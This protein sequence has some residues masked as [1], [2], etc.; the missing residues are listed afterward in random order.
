MDSKQV[1]QFRQQLCEEHNKIRTN[2][3]SYV[4]VL[5]QYLKYFQGNVFKKPGEKIGIQT[6]E[7]KAAVQEC[8][9]FLKKQKAEDAL[10]LDDELSKAAQ[11]HVDDI[12]P[13]GITGHDGSD[14]STVDDRI[15]RYVDWGA[16]IAENI[17]FGS[18]T[19]QDVIISLAVDDGVPSRGH[20]E[21]LFNPDFRYVGVGFGEHTEFRHATVLDYCG[22][23]EGYK[24]TAK[25]GNKAGNTNS[26]SKATGGA[27]NK[28]N[29]LANLVRNFDERKAKHED[30]LKDDED[31]PENTVGVSIKT[32]TKSVNGKIVKKTIKTYTLD[33]G[34]VET[35]E[36]TTEQ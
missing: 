21:N 23:I 28:N 32:I 26:A 13:Q 12:G 4:P 29:V 10:I 8:I 34:S 14:G 1:V 18:Q 7:G 9:S 36:V 24:N 20:R 17:D 30:F 2:P 27:T 35:V 5:E 31:A 25:S 22:D 16:T 3:K 33:D 11:D 15:S 6:N 19:P